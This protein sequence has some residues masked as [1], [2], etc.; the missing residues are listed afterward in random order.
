MLYII[1]EKSNYGLTDF[2][3]RPVYLTDFFYTD[4]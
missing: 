1:G 4:Q 3:Y 2:I